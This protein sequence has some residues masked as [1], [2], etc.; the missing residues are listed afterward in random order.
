MSKIHVEYSQAVS[1]SCVTNSSI[2][3]IAMISRT[4]NHGYDFRDDFNSTVRIIAMINSTV[5]HSYDSRYDF[6]SPIEIIM[7]IMIPME[8]YYDV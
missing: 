4:I 5:N 7:M 8:S 1:I 2:G 3:F 6:N